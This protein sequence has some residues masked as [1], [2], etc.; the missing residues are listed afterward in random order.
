MKKSAICLVG[1]FLVLPM[2]SYAISNFSIGS[3][4]LVIP[5]V[6]VDGDLYYDNVSLKLDFN[7]GAFELL[8]ATATVPP[9]PDK[10]IET[11]DVEDF[12]LSF[13]G[14][15][16][17]GRDEVRCYMKITNNDFDRD[18]FVN[19]S[20]NETYSGY[21]PNSKLYDELNHE[22]VASK[23]TIANKEVNSGDRI[24]GVK[25]IR[26]IPAFAVFKFNGISPSASSL[27]LFKPGFISEDIQ[28]QGDFRSFGD[29]FF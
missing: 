26:G 10:I 20:S 29:S 6:Y 17:T 24:G 14:C 13:Q 4:V 16:R 22:Y 3:G 27:S 5:R 19:L 15:F 12:S 9:E 25:M 28:F 8:N 1:I 23:I 11:Q 7:T 2:Y 21:A 18:L